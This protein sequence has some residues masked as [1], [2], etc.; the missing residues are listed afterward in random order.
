ME[1]GMSNTIHL[2]VQLVKPGEIATAHRHVAAAIRYVLK[3]S[4]KSFTIVEGERFTME[5][6]DLITTP[7]WTWHD[8]FNGTVREPIQWGADITHFF[9]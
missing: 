8:H 5:E 1:G 7:N 9:L 4:P 3:G 2:S 6:G